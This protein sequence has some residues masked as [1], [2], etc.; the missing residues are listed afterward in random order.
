[1]AERVDAGGSE[2]F[3]FLPSDGKEFVLGIFFHGGK[4]LRLVQWT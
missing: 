3:Q 1:L 4:A 2:G